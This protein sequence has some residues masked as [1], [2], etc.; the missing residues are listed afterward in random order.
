MT[1]MVM[2]MMMMMMKTKKKITYDGDNYGITYELIT[3]NAD[4][5]GREV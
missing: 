5:S 3:Q 1:M 4:Y 2:M